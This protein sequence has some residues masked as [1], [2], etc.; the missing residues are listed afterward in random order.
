M[1]RSLRR[2]LAVLLNDPNYDKNTSD[3]VALKPDRLVVPRHPFTTHLFLPG[4]RGALP[5]ARGGDVLPRDTEQPRELAP[6]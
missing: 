6:A 1:Q 4:R 5:V 2:A 3:N